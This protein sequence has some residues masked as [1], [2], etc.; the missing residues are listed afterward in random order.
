MGGA[1]TVIVAITP[2]PA[3]DRT[4]VVA[5]LVVG[6]V[7]R[8]ANAVEA[9]GGKGLNVA[10]AIRS[11]GGE[12]VA[13]GPIGGSVGARIRDLAVS[14]GITTGFTR[15]HGT[16]RI[17]TILTNQSG[18]STVVNEVGPTLSDV[19]WSV[20]IADIHSQATT[21]DVVT[22]SG[23][24]PVAS[25]ADLLSRVTAGCPQPAG[26][27]WIDS[28]PQWVAAAVATGRSVKVNH[29]EAAAALDVDAPE[30]ERTSWAVDAARQLVG[31]G[32]YQ[33]MITL[34]SE[35]AVWVTPDATLKAVAP[36][37]ATVNSVGSG[38]SLLGALAVGIAG[39]LPSAEVFA[40]AIAAG[41][42][43]ATTP[44]AA[45]LDQRLVSELALEVE[46]T[47]V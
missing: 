28:G 9:A 16:S 40:Y 14:E 26:H 1:R 13:M 31:L 15:I 12:V 37:V 25:T 8:G 3:L 22:I 10:R 34:G 2:N 4:V 29:H 21:A 46:V 47:I 5:D 20:V 6:G 36:T 45:T 35:G 18:E 38:D 23:S 33:C 11:L 42:A 27:V 32:A 39:G 44:T 19:E 43:N 24:W 7:H 17:C 41:A 30:I